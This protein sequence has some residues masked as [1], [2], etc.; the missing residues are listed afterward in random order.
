MGGG[1]TEAVSRRTSEAGLKSVGSAP[2][3]ATGEP[4][5]GETV[6]KVF[7][8]KPPRCVCTAIVLLSVLAWVGSIPM[9]MASLGGSLQPHVGMLW[10]VVTA[11]GMFVVLVQVDQRIAAAV[12]FCVSFASA[13]AAPG[14]DQ[15]RTLL[16]A[17]I[18][19]GM[20][21]LN[22][23]KKLC[24]PCPETSDFAGRCFAGYFRQNELRGA[25][26]SM[27]PGRSFYAVH[28]HGILSAGWITNIIWGNHFHSAAG[29][30]FYLI[31]GTLRNKGLIARL[32]CDAYEGPHGGLRDT[33]SA[34]LRSLMAR[35]ESVAMI[36]G[37]YQ[38]AT[39]FSHGRERVALLQRKGFVKY[40]LRYGYRLHPIYTFGESDTY[41]TMGGLMA[42]RLWLNTYGV[43]T[44]AFCGKPWC[45]VLPRSEARLLTYVGEPVELPQIAEPTDT[46]VEFWHAKYVQALRSMFD[47]YKEEAGCPDAVLEVL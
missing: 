36:P 8:D 17:F 28:P 15:R 31:D 29:R 20:T 39:Q 16:C 11:V 2:G 38:E 6:A 13:Y 5:L 21:L 9:L 27:R 25:L 46:E 3:K 41:V 37:A 47:K 26:H 14:E 1:K 43:P 32:W 22:G 33:S 18:A 4:A 44:V 23:I 34:S 45:P 24:P 30:C 42:L 19:T 35:Q 40:C 10:G 7:D 12:V